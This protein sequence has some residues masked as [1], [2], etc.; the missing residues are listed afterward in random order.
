MRGD[1]DGDG[2]VGGSVTD[3][4]FLLGW[5]FN[6]GREPVCYAACDVDGD[7]SLSNPVGEA[8]YYASWTFL[9]G[10]P[11]TQPFPECGSLSAGDE[12]V[13]CDSST[14][15]CAELT[16][17]DGRYQTVTMLPAQDC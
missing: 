10:S 16:V 17:S 2:S 14:G 5:A 4:I 8:V 11:P 6:A 1:C 9:G 3:I 12:A 15:A 7:G 13:G